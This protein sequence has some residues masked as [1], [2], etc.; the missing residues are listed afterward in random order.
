M[1]RWGKKKKRKKEK[2]SNVYIHKYNSKC[3]KHIKKIKK[4]STNV[5]EKSN[6]SQ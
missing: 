1:T 6:F 5:E 4:I 2:T 3:K